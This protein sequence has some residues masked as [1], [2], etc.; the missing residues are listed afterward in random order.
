MVDWL[1]QFEYLSGKEAA[2]LHQVCA[3]NGWLIALKNPSAT[4]LLRAYS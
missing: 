4:N 1:E 3:R 2:C